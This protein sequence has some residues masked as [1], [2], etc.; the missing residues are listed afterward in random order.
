MSWRAGFTPGLPRYVTGQ[1]EEALVPSYLETDF[2]VAD[3]GCLPRSF[4]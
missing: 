1:A 3:W 4:G 2:F